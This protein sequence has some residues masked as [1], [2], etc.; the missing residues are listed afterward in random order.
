M[1]PILFVSHGGGPLPI[2]NHPSHSDMLRAFA[3]ILDYLHAHF[4]KPDAIVYVSAHW[5]R[6]PV[7]ITSA[8]TP[9]LFY[10]YYNFPPE[11]YALKYPVPGAP[12]LAA[13]L[14]QRLEAVGIEAVLDDSRGLDHGVFIP[15][16]LLHPDAD[17]PTLQISLQKG[18]SAERH[19]KIGEALQGLAA[20]NILVIGSGYSFHNMQAFFGPD[21]AND[22]A[23]N[24]AFEDWILTTLA[25]PDNAARQHQLINWEEAPHARFCHPREEHLL[26]LH[27]CVGAAGDA[28][29][30]RSWSF[31][32]LN[33]R[34]SC[35]LWK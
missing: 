4:A 31:T 29:L 27:V 32:A 21:N 11:S 6:E 34:G 22:N 5:E 10:D 17:I 25:E 24:Q 1:Q 33:K 23:K 2:L 15:G 13:D 19:L 18:L 7:A 20:E 28:P 26:P 9:E 16:L 35:H 12:K 30:Q 14:Q 8:A 3:E